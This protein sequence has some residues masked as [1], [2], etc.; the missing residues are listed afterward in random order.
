VSNSQY[1]N[2][3]QTSNQVFHHEGHEAHEEFLL[4]MFLRVLRAL[5]GDSFSAGL[6]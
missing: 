4:E 2:R 1:G 5:R 6:A 3:A